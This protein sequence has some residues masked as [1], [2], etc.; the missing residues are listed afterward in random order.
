VQ[1]DQ[2]QAVLLATG[3]EVGLALE[4]HK[5]LTA[6]GLRVS[7]VSMPSTSVFDRQ[8]AA[9]QASV[10]PAGVPRVAIEAGV[11]AGWWKYLGGKGAVVGIDTFGESAPANV[12]F[13]HFG[14]TAE[15]VAAAVRGLL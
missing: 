1:S 11:T 15:H 7:I 3:S 10:L 9:Y 4:A 14:F 6:E 12:L 13:K 8:D 2:P 5:L